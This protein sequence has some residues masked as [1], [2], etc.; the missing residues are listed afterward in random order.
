M[1]VKDIITKEREELDNQIDKLL[2][3]SNKKLS[4]EL[5]ERYSGKKYIEMEV[6]FLIKKVEV[7]WDLCENSSGVVLPSS[8]FRIYLTELNG[9]DADDYI[10]VSSADVFNYIDF[11]NCR[12][13]GF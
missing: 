4:K 2:I 5:T 6:E 12:G 11:C 13:M 7:Y 10:N 3:E 9:R 1:K 8:M